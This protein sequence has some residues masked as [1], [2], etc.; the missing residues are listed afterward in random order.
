MKSREYDFA[1][2]EAVVARYGFKIKD[3]VIHASMGKDTSNRACAA[4]DYL[5]RFHGCMLSAK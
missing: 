1:R 5:I 2:A 4:L 3:R